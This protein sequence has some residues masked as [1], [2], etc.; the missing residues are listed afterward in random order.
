METELEITKNPPKM[1]Q[2]F[3]NTKEDHSRP[4][5]AIF[6]RVQSYE[7]WIKHNAQREDIYPDVDKSLFDFKLFRE[8]RNDTSRPVSTSIVTHL[9]VMYLFHRNIRVF[10]YAIN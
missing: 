5:G 3:Y 1:V 6:T 2:T 10:H 7:K 9:L 8:E 4:W